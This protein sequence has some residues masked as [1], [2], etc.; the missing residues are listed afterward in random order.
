MSLVERLVDHLWPHGADSQPAVVG[1]HYGEGCTGKQPSR[2]PRALH[3][4]QLVPERFQLLIP[5]AVLK[6]AHLGYGHS[7]PAATNNLLGPLRLLAILCARRLLA[8]LDL[9]HR[10]SWRRVEDELGII[11]PGEVH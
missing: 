8:R 1:P 7:V 11:G 10:G 2:T 4:W 5:L 6:V 9:G 3:R